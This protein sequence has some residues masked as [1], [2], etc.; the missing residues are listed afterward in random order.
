MC[1][2]NQLD[3]GSSFASTNKNFPGAKRVIKMY[4]LAQRFSVSGEKCVVLPATPETKEAL[5]IPYFYQPPAALEFQRLRLTR[6]RK[7]MQQKQGVFFY[8]ALSSCYIFNICK[9]H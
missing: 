4:S 5:N 2:G 8:T 6:V 7:L 9:H 1:Q 3:N